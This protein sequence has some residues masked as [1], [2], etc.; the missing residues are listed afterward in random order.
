MKCGCA[1]EEEDGAD[2]QSS[3]DDVLTL[4]IPIVFGHAVMVSRADTT[5]RRYLGHVYHPRRP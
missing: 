2:E 4:Y 5:S 1:V 3:S